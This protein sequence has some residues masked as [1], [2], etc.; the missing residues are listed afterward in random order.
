MEC[1]EEKLSSLHSVQLGPRNPE[2]LILFVAVDVSFRNQ[3]LTHK[4]YSWR[5]CGESRNC[6]VGDWKWE[7]GNIIYLFGEPRIAEMSKEKRPR[8]HIVAVELH[9][10]LCCAGFTPWRG[11]F[12]SW[13][14]D[15]CIYKWIWHLDSCDI[16]LGS[17]HF[18]PIFMP[19][20]FWSSNRGPT[21][22]HLIPSRNFVFVPICSCRAWSIRTES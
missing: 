9:T 7:R 12:E 19:S 15:T 8:T 2:S 21:D 17:T 20:L 11:P 3:L 10:P 6:D 18:Q 16:P 1:S 13:R 5:C 22:P 14:L 4:V